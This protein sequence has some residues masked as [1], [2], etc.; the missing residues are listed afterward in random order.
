MSTEAGVGN[1]AR[2][3]TGARISQVGSNKRA[4]TRWP[5]REG[6]RMQQFEFCCRSFKPPSKHPERK[7]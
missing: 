3:G 5:V 1:H 2:E 4:C 7:R 6:S